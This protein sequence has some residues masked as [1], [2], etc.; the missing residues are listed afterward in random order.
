MEEFHVSNLPPITPRY[1]IAPSQDV[2]AVRETGTGREMVTLRW[3][4]LPSWAK[5]GKSTYR[6][7][8][9]RAETVADKPAY[10]AAFRRRRCLLP[11]DGFYE[12]Q[13]QADGKQP[14]HIRMKDS[15]VFAFAGLW[16]HWEGDDQVIESCTIIVTGANEV[17]RPIHDRM[18]VIINRSDYDQWLDPEVQQAEKLAPLLRPFASEQMTVYPVSK[19]VNSPAR[20]DVDCIKADSGQVG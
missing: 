13:A 20:D 1:N 17:V 5:D 12:W 8:N 14:W 4:L 3:G 7:I 10:R 18:P 9:A 6:M 16:E 19:R 11:A 2:L 15:N